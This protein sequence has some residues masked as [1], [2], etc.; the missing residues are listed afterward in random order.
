MSSRPRCSGSNGR[1]DF[2]SPARSI[3]ARSISSL[4]GR[5][6]GSAN[7]EKGSSEVHRDEHETK[8]VNMSMTLHSGSN[9][10]ISPAGAPTL[11]TRLLA[12]SYGAIAYVVFLGTFSIMAAGAMGWPIESRYCRNARE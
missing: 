8:E 10:T 3:A 11:A 6:L 12:L 7:G 1:K 2:N 9:E 4:L 5:Q